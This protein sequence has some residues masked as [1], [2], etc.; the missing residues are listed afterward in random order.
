MSRLQ[1]G[2][3][4][5]ATPLRGH[6]LWKQTT[7]D[8]GTV[9]VTR[10]DAH[11]QFSDETNQHQT[12]DRADTAQLTGTAAYMCHCT[13]C[14][15]TRPPWTDIKQ[16]TLNLQFNHLETLDGTVWPKIIRIMIT[17]GTSPAIQWL[18]LCLSMRDGGVRS[19][20]WEI[21]SHMPLAEAKNFFFKWGE[22]CAEERR[23]LQRPRP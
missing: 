5:T 20:V 19:L 15:S 8:N 17:W 23:K 16:R 21:G 14:G 18:R 12:A 9:W 2:R 4:H 6:E 1:A 10:L 13:R 11:S 3:S 7:A 22:E